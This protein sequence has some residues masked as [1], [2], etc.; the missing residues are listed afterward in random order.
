LVVLLGLG[1]TCRA[2]AD[3]PPGPSGP[4]WQGGGPLGP[5]G[6]PG[7][8]GEPPYRLTTAVKVP[9]DPNFPDQQRRKLG[10]WATHFGNGCGSFRS[11]MVFIFGSCRA[12]YGEACR[13]GPPSVYPA[14]Y[15]PAGGYGQGGNGGPGGPGGG[16]CNCNS[17]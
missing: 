17:W 4:P 16:N 10:C 11:D 8:V 9:T 13:K 1:L 12:F 5:P 2:T 3:G 15:G 6:P 7:P 14:G